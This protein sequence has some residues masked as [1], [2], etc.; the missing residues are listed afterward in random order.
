MNIG[1]R[2]KLYRKK[3]NMTQQEAAPLI[4]IKS[5]QLANYESNR[6]EPNIKVLI[7]MS[8]VYHVSIDTLL[9]NDKS[10]DTISNGQLDHQD[11]DQ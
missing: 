11:N 10:L 7:G 2:F 4:G 1:R 5:Y 6:S 8:K 9:G 3:M